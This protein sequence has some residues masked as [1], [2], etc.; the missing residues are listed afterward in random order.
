MQMMPNQNCCPQPPRQPRQMQCPPE[1]RAPERRMPEERRPREE[2]RECSCTC[3]D[4][5]MS[6]E[7]LMK[8]ITLSGF[9]MFDAS[10]YLDTH[11]GDTE[12]IRYFNE[13][14]HIYNEA[15]AEYSEKFTPLTVA[16]AH[17]NDRYWDW[18]NQPW[19]WQ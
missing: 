19:P 16:H 9:A 5:N 1:R 8:R 4:G 6:R 2:R 12:A 17:H 11:P 3:N 13:Q 18:V 10:L 14:S 15:L 7:K